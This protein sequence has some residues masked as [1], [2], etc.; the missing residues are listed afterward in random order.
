MGDGYFIN[1]VV[2]R[3]PSPWRGGGGGGGTPHNDLYGGAF[4]RGGGGGGGEG[5]PYNDLYEEAP[6]ERGLFSLV[7]VY[8][9]GGNLSFRSVK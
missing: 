3:G 7:E 6:T 5:T 8:E 9:R 4:P 2:K 1:R